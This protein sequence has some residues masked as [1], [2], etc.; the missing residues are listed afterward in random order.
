MRLKFWAKPAVPLRGVEPMRLP[1]VSPPAPEPA[2]DLPIIVATL[3]PPGAAASVATVTP[4]EPG[5][6]SAAAPERNDEMPQDMHAQTEL[7]APTP[8][9]LPLRGQLTTSDARAERLIRQIRGEVEDLRQTLEDISSSQEEMVTLDLPS[10]VADPEAAKTLAPAVL[11]RGLI[12]AHEEHERLRAQ[13]LEQAQ[14]MTEMVST[15]HTLREEAAMRRGRLETLD[16]VVAA[17][18]ANLQDF[19]GE[20]DFRMPPTPAIANGV[21]HSALGKGE[22]R[23][24]GF[25]ATEATVEHT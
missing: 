23:T 13:V 21:H 4:S 7:P 24:N 25:L 12:A 5:L 10:V 9:P 17:L 11:V 15:I 16:Q 22:P 14:A 18:H 8:F 1:V 2:S 6:P 19:R 20:R 3:E